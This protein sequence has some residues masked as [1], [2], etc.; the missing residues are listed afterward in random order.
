MLDL[1]AVTNPDWTE[2]PYGRFRWAET[3][4]SQKKYREAAKELEALLAEVADDT[5]V[6]HGFGDAR[7]LL[8]RSHFH[9]A[10]LKAAERET[11]T[12]L[13]DDPADGYA[14]LLMG[15]I[16]QRQNRK[17]EAEPFLARAR[18]RAM[19]VEL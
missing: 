13:A 15:R 8:A 10:Q 5:D 16:L 19:G 7:L 2:D 3:L 4:F 17:D 11:R 12:L 14:A 9:A 1:N 18:A 6:R